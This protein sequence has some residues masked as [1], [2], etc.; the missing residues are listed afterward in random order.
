MPELKLDSEE[1]G[2]SFKPVYS[3]NFPHH[4][5]ILTHV[6][7]GNFGISMIKPCRRM[8]GQRRERG[9]GGGGQILLKCRRTRLSLSYRCSRRGSAWLGRRGRRG[10][11]QRPRGTQRAPPPRRPGPRP[12]PRRRP[13][14]SPPSSV[15]D[16]NLLEK[17]RRH[18][19]FST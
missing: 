2:G 14:P 8:F 9:G 19:V 16:P 17:C 11:R 3:R 4:H 10:R 15:V 7:E 18:N 5:Y 1:Y 13:E 12:P 6:V